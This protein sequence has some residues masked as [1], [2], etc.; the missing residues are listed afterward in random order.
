MLATFVTS[1]PA[2]GLQRRDAALPGG[3]PAVRLGGLA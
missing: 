2:G 1:V 3:R